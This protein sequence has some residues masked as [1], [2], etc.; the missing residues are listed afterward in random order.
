MIPGIFLISFI[1]QLF[2][3]ERFY[4]WFFTLSVSNLCLAL[5]MFLFFKET[6]GLTDKQKKELYSQK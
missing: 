6:T 1:E 4:A 3:R 5:F 2:P